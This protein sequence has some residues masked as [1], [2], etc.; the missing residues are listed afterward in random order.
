MLVIVG[1]R[2]TNK[3]PHCSSPEV[4]LTRCHCPREATVR[5]N[6]RKGGSGTAVVIMTGAIGERSGRHD[7]VCIGVWTREGCVQ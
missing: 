7:I 1:Q 2:V 3:M 4:S 6:Q 5:L